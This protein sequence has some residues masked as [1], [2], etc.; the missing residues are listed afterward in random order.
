M[1]EPAW[2]QRPR[3]T[4]R[5]TGRPV[6]AA[7]EQPKLLNLDDVEAEEDALP[8]PSGLP[9]LRKPP[10]DDA[11]QA[12]ERDLDALPLRRPP[13]EPRPPSPPSEPVADEY[14]DW[15][16]GL[17]LAPRQVP[18]GFAGR[19]SIMPLEFQQDSHFVPMPDR[20]RSGSRSGTATARTIASSSRTTRS[21]RTRRTFVAGASIPIGRTCSRATI[22]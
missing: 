6:V 22:R 5:V 4:S 8:T 20:W 2:A 14:L 21:R 12:A 9:N 15:D 7:T 11:D 1:L 3:A 10:T 17:L 18:N 13:G 19:S 16:G